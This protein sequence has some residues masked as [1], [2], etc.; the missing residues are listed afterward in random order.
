MKKI[1]IIICILMAAVILLAG[2]SGEQTA[3]ITELSDLEGKI[4]AVLSTPQD[5]E[6]M[7]AVLEQ[8]AGVSLAEVKFFDTY[9]GA[10]AALKSNQADAVAVVGPMTDYYLSRN[11]DINA[12]H[13][14]PV[15][16]TSIHMALRADDTE[17]RDR[18]NAAL[19]EMKNEGTL[20]R[21]EQEYITDL[22]PEMQYEGKEM[23]FFE[24]AETLIM[25]LSGDSPPLDYAAADGKPAGYNAELLTLLSE[26]LQMNIE[27]SVMPTESKFPALAAGRI[28][29]FFFHATNADIEMTQKTMEANLSAMLTEPYYSFSGSAFLVLK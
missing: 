1:T 28:D 4:V 8:M 18:V 2:C 14:E 20:A 17:L 22:K 5:P 10:L 21:L 9:S 11:D 26:K 13:V 23:P 29:M 25:G 16:V 19:N 7:K 24:G 6:M 3:K 27:T 12:L 15:G